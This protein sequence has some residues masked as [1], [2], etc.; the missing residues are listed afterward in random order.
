MKANT[1]TDCVVFLDSVIDDAIVSGSAL[2][3]FATLYRGMTTA[4]QAGI[5][6]N[7]FDDGPRMERLVVSFANRYFDAYAAF[8][9]GSPVTKSWQTAF[10]AAT[11]PNLTIVQH[12]LLGINAHINLDLG[13]AAAGISTPATIA[14]LHPD[15]QRI[16]DTIATEYNI[17]QSRLSRISWLMI[18]MAR[19]DPDKTNALINFSISKARDTAWANAQILCHASPETYA[20]VLQTTDH[21]VATIAQRIHVPGKIAGFLFKWI[22]K[23]EQK[24]IASNLR[25]LNER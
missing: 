10:L 23:A 1:L 12:L 9:T 19:L 16:N 13:A 4:V 14:A 25:I 7:V 22:R 5:A 17:L 21:L 24:S 2:G 15:F 20:H 18:F 3:Y 8:R 11:S 6:A